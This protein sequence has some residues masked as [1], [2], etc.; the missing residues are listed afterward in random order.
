MSFPAT[1][2]CSRL[3]ETAIHGVIASYH[4]PSAERV[5]EY[6]IPLARP[7]LSVAGHG[8]KHWRNPL[9]R[10]TTTLPA[11]PWGSILIHLQVGTL[12]FYCFALHLYYL[13]FRISI[14]WQIPPIKSSTWL[15]GEE[16]D[17]TPIGRFLPLPRAATSSVSQRTCSHNALRLV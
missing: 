2:R 5:L 7:P 12:E 8:I 1:A 3:V 13:P 4:G 6:K 14:P 17:S 16:Q 10:V 15:S 11:S 9:N